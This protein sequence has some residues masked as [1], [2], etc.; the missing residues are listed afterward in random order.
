MLGY[1]DIGVVGPGE[2]LGF[3]ELDSNAIAVTY[4]LTEDLMNKAG[5]KVL[6]EK[7]TK[8]GV[9][10]AKGL[11]TDSLDFALK[12]LLGNGQKIPE[13]AIRMDIVSG[14]NNSLINGLPENTEVSSDLTLDDARDKLGYS[15]L[16]AYSILQHARKNGMVLG[17]S[18]LFLDNTPEAF[19]VNDNGV[20][21]GCAEEIHDMFFEIEALKGLE[22]IDPRLGDFKFTSAKKEQSPDLPVVM[23]KHYK[24]EGFLSP[25]N[26]IFQF[27][28]SHTVKHTLPNILHNVAGMNLSKAISTCSLI[29]TI[30]GTLGNVLYPLSNTLVR[31]TCRGTLDPSGKKVVKQPIMALK[32][33][34]VKDDDA[35]RADAILDSDS[36]ELSIEEMGELISGL[37]GKKV[38]KKK[39]GTITVTEGGKT[40]KHTVEDPTLILDKLKF[41]V[42]SVSFPLILGP[43]ATDFTKQT[44]R[45][46]AGHRK[47]SPPAKVVKVTPTITTSNNVDS[48]VSSSPAGRPEAADDLLQSQEAG[49][50]EYGL[51]VNRG[52][53]MKASSTD[54]DALLKSKTSQPEALKDAIKANKEVEAQRAR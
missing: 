3:C 38:E 21:L 26:A 46:F 41:D 12:K 4:T 42:Y 48:N 54:M 18:Y 30:Q 10:Y 8:V 5:S 11:K 16:T 2:G 19:V 32:E 25:G 29:S 34:E 51:A 15:G 52:G 31:T 39:V 20:Q 22:I 24:P 49:N 53:L 28:S 45:F 27:H 50:I 1:D 36:D 14:G 33:V 7:G 17:D 9:H 6:V 23:S 43:N 35:L 13:G 37:S 44:S 47:G 40:R